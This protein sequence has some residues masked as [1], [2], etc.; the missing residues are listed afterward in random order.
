M[1]HE[2][3]PRQVGVLADVVPH[4]LAGDGSGKSRVTLCSGAGARQS[5]NAEI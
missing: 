2:V 1:L 5:L 3:G 4:A